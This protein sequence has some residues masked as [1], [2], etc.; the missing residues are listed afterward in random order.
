VP[1]KSATWYRLTPRPPAFL[2]AQLSV[3]DIIDALASAFGED[4]AAYSHGGVV[5]VGEVSR[6]RLAQLFG[7]RVTI[8]ASKGPPWRKLENGS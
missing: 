2:R 6:E 4:K 5:W 1:R 3:G 7:D 8:E